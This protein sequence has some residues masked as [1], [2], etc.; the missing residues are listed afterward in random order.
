MVTA[1]NR[2]HHKSMIEEPN[3]WPYLHLPLKNSQD[4]EPGGFPQCSLTF[5][6]K[7]D[8]SILIYKINLWMLP[9]TDETPR[10][11]FQ[12]VDALLDAGWVVD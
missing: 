12:D 5:G 2:F 10:E 11:T 7:E 8:G 6:P 3:R 9:I 1:T 4:R